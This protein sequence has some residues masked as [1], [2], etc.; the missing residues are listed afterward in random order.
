MRLDKKSIKDENVMKFEINYYNELENKK[1]STDIEY[2]FKKEIIE[3]EYYSDAKI[4]TAL[5]LYYFGK[6]NRRYMKI[7]NNENKKKKYDKEYI[8][9]KEFKIEKDKI[10]K[11]MKEHLDEKKS[12]KLNETI[13]NDYIEKMDKFVDKAIQYCNDNNKNKKI[14]NFLNGNNKSVLNKGFL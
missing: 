5:A 14:N 6:F 8:K 7:C 9:R 1:E 12:D 13:V 10:K 11:Y 2:S 4:E 3:K